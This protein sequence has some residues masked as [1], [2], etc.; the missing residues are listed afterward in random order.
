MGVDD[1]VDLGHEADR[2]VE[3]HDDTVVMDE[4]VAIEPP[5]LAVLEPFL[6]NLVAADVEIP[7][8]FR[9][10]AETDRAGDF[11]SAEPFFGLT[12]SIQT[13]SSDQPTLSTTGSAGPVKATQTGGCVAYA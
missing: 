10:T 1:T 7:D 2:F 13:V 5:S 3:G 12:A 11:A 8:L 4:I 6:T 9:R